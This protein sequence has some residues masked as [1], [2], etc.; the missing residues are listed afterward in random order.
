MST[1][2]GSDKQEEHS[3]ST[4]DLVSTPHASHIFSLWVASC[5]VPED[6]C[7][8]GVLTA[9]ASSSLV[10]SPKILVHMLWGCFAMGTAAQKRGLGGDLFQKRAPDPNSPRVSEAFMQ[11]DRSETMEDLCL[12]GEHLKGRQDILVCL[13]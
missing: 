8:L 3:H 11:V 2:G 6:E 9:R 5:L 12:S 1:S 10:L 4:R 7:S 13:Q